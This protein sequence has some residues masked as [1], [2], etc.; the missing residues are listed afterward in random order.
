MEKD[1][2]KMPKVILHLHLDGS[3]RP[4]TAKEWISELLGKE[5]SLEDTKKMLMVEKGCRDLNEYLQKFDVPVKLLQTSEHIEKAVYELYEDLSKQNVIYAEVRFAP[6]KHIL[7]GLS[8]D[9]VVE[10]ALNGLNKAKK[11]FEIDGNLILC[12][13]RGDDNEQDNIKTV[14]TA[15]KYLTKGVCAVDLAGAEALFKTK[16]FENIFAKARENNV[17]FTI[18][19][20]EADGVESMR[21]ALNFGATRIGHG[22]RC[23]DDE[24]LVKELVEKQI[25]LE[26]CP[27]SN[28]Q[29]Q[30]VVGKHPIEQLFRKG[31]CVTVSPDNNT[32]SNTDI[33]EENKY[34]LENTSLTPD[35]LI[36]MNLNAARNIFGTEKQKKEL[37]EKISAYRTANTLEER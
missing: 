16:N 12:C 1:I 36:Q 29:T 37:E 19:A 15:Q 23:I 26:I 30:A 17:P 3:L 32:V 18:H 33:L 6:S 14:E 27:I 21:T 24:E 13:M 35:D 5:V 11:E 20:G 9:V 31:I 7:G 8:Y 34:I 10:S 25:P 4:E 22:V 28:L 2:K